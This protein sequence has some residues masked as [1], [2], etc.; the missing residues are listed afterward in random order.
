MKKLMMLT[1]ITI[2]SIGITSVDAFWG[3]AYYGPPAP[4]YGG[5]YGPDAGAVAATTGGVALGS[6]LGTA[7]ASSG[8]SSKRSRT[9]KRQ[10]QELKKKEAEIARL[11]GQ[12]S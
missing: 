4:Y 1:L 9:I 6:M 2:A 3:P 12:K 7:I 5:Y 8:N 10:R 11:K